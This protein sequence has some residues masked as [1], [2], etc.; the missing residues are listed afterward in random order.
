MKGI[1][2]VPHSEVQRRI[3]EHRREAAGNPNRPR[4]KRK[5]KPSTPPDA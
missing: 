4:L 1:L 2:A 3:E 5:V